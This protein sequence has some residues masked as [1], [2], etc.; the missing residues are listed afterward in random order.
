MEPHRRGQ[1]IAGMQGLTGALFLSPPT[2]KSGLKPFSFVPL[3]PHTP[4]STKQLPLV[5]S[6][7]S[8]SGN[9]AQQHPCGVGI[10]PHSLLDPRRGEQQHP[11]RRKAW[12]PPLPSSISSEAQADRK[13]LKGAAEHF[14]DQEDH[15]R[16]QASYT[17]TKTYLQT[18][19]GIGGQ[20]RNSLI[21]PLTP[22]SQR[23]PSAKPPSLS[24]PVPRS[25][26]IYKSVVR[27][28]TG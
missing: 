25:E 6:G 19:T 24:V 17:D 5:V 1:D 16:Y 22:L 2:Q 13:L 15:G 10:Y 14:L 9:A 18:Q 3:P 28:E 23:P 8:C 27:G 4:S 12:T 21:C 7:Q 20:R 26:P 11:W